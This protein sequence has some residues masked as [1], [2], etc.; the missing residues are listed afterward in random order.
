MKKLF[1]LIIVLIGLTGMLYSQNQ[2]VWYV[3]IVNG[4]AMYSGLNPTNNPPGMGPK[5]TISDIINTGELRDGDIINIAAGTYRDCPSIS[6]NITINGYRLQSLTEIRFILSSRSMVFNMNGITTFTFENSTVSNPSTSGRF[7]FIGSSNT[8]MDIRSGKIL[9]AAAFNI[10]SPFLFQ[11]CTG[12][13]SLTSASNI[14][15]SAVN[16]DDV[17]GDGTLS[18]PYKTFTK[19]N[20]AVHERDHINL[21]AGSYHENPVVIKNIFVDGS[22]IGANSEVGFNLSTSMIFNMPGSVFFTASDSTIF[23]FSSTTNAGINFKTGCVHLSNTSFYFNP[24]FLLQGGAL[25]NGS[26]RGM[27][28]NDLNGNGQLDS[29]EPGIANWK[30]NLT[31]AGS[32]TQITDSLGNYSFRNLQAGTYYVSED[33]LPGWRQTFPLGS[34]RTINL[35]ENSSRYGVNFGNT[36]VPTCIQHPGGMVAWWPL[37]ENTGL[38]ANDIAGLQHNNGKHIGNP[39][40]VPAKVLGGLQFDGVNDYIEVPHESE[41]DIDTCD[42]SIEG[43]IKTED[44]NVQNYRTILDKRSTT[45]NIFQGYWLYHL[46]GKPGLELVFNNVQTQY[47]ST[48]NIT[49]GQWHYFVVTV[50]RGNP[51]KVIWYNDGIPINTITSPSVQAGSLTN[52]NPLRIGS[53][54]FRVST[55]FK[56]VLDEVGIYKRVLTEQEI[57]SIFT[58]GSAG[59]CK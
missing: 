38:V 9:L 27:K 2:R 13:D 23:R 30:I 47:N 19:A 46:N 20:S 40:P 41:I 16:G 56:G 7:V 50:K 58:S 4:N 54:S 17:F 22:Q 15:V 18:N 44:S 3:D 26:I 14:Y 48:V 55:L 11:S 53:R 42:F 36:Q 28:F 31:G 57:S 25:A 51:S 6:Q 39:I 1:K 34:F 29:D 10:M 32:A 33:S 52:D 8:G 43:W 12:Q 35:S 24:P 59:K 5:S 49:D 21:Q 37:D 45:P